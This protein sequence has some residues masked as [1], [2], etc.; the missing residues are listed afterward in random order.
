M[1]LFD[2]LFG[3]EEQPRHSGNWTDADDWQCGEQ[4]DHDGMYGFDSYE[5]NDFWDKDAFLGGGHSFRFIG[6]TFRGLRDP[7]DDG[8]SGFDIYE[9]NDF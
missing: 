9:D 3:S 1:A 5:E 6:R 8:M 4:D 2:F 7:S